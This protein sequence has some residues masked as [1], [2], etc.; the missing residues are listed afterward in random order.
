MR[1]SGLK[2]SFSFVGFYNFIV[3]YFEEKDDAASVKRI[4][5]LLTWWN[6]WVLAC[7]E[8][9]IAL[10]TFHCSQVFPHHAVAT[11]DSNDSC[12][13]LQAQQAHAAE[14]LG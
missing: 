4:E 12:N 8:Y 7:L 10:L 1:P 5:K 9:Y 2:H 14:M 3:D 6:W 13:K 11:I